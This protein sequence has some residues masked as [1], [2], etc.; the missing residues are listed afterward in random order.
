MKKKILVISS[1]RSDYD[2]YYPILSSLKKTKKA[3]LLVYLTCQ[4]YNKIFSNDI[5][6]INNEFEILKNPTNKNNFSDGALQMVKNLSHDLKNLSTHINIRK[7]DLIIVMGDRYE[8]LIGPLAAMPFNI[9]TIHFFGGAVTEGAMDELI[10]HGITKMSHIHFVLLDDYKKRLQNLGEESW[11]IKVIGMPSLNKKN[12]LK[13][14]I[15]KKQNILNKFTK[16]KPF[17][18]LTFHPVTLEIDHTEMQIKSLIKAVKKSKINA[19]ITYPNSDPKFNLIIKLFKKNFLN[20]KKIMFVK[21]A[22]EEQYF[23]LMKKAQFMIGNSS[24]GIVEA[25]SF[26]LPV[27]NIGSRQKGKLKPKNVIDTGYHHKEILRAMKKAL[28]K[29]FK[30]SISK[31]KNPYTSKINSKD[32]AKMILKI[33]KNGNVIKKKFHDKRK[34]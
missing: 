30:K 15:K 6:K 33:K 17:M 32:L 7:P 10:R 3:K 19:I 4:N 13:N 2:R 26:K 5:N 12:I 8:M 9:P 27:V 16:T 24:S 11:R 21:S 18:L 1:G 23:N 34:I 22:G 25:A 28:S 20:S 14:K 29:G 31:I